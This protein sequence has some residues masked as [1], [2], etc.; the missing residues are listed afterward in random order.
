MRRQVVPGAVGGPL[1]LCLPPFGAIKTDLEKVFRLP[2]TMPTI[3][4]L[5]GFDLFC[6]FWVRVGP[7]LIEGLASRYA[8][9][10]ALG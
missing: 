8:D 7:T 9:Q 6:R 3:G 5:L 10:Q 2:D 1:F 4:V